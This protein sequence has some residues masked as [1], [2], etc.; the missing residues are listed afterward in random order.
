MLRAKS[1]GDDEDDCDGDPG[2]AFEEMDVAVA[3][4]GEDHGEDGDNDDGGCF[5]DFVGSRDGLESLTTDDTV[6]S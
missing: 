4:E 2:V 6:D 3:E 1:E 5:R